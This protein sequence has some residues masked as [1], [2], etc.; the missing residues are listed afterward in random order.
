MV[1]AAPSHCPDAQ[2]QLQDT[3]EALGDHGCGRMMM[4]E[5]DVDYL[6][7]YGHGH[8]EDQAEFWFD[9]TE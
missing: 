3:G 5:K 6:Q 9:L 8:E 2:H 1:T 7:W 4:L